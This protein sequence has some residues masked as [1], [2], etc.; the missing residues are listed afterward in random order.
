MKTNF[1][2]DLSGLDNFVDQDRFRQEVELWRTEGVPEATGV[3]FD[4][5]GVMVLVVAEYG[6]DNK[7]LS[8][9]VSE[10]CALRDS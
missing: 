7:F 6:K 5:K 4:D 2:Y 1:K 8:I 3:V 10:H 9:K